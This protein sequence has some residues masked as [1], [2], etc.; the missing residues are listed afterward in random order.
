[1]EMERKEWH[2]QPSPVTQ[3]APNPDY[4]FTLLLD[5]S[6]I[7][8]GTA[9]AQATFIFS[10]ESGIILSDFPN[11]FVNI[12]NE[13]AK[14]LKIRDRMMVKIETPLGS[15]SLPAYTTLRAGRGTLLFPLYLWEKV[16]LALGGVELDRSLGM[17]IFKPLPA[18]IGKEE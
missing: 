7:W 15:L 16:S 9:M 6:Y 8:S 10:R 12:N 3:N 11:G 1:V 17:P 18:R 2:P 4:P 14:E 13:D 5:P